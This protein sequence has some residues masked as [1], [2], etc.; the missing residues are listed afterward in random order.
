MDSQIK[1][2]VGVIFVLFGLFWAWLTV[3]DWKAGTTGSSGVRIVKLES[4][5]RFGLHIAFN[6]ALA[7]GVAVLGIWSMLTS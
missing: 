7:V 4:P 6:L 2:I 5:R 3:R 1:V